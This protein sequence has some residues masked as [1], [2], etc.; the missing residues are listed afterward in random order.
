LWPARYVALLVVTIQL[1]GTGLSG[2]CFLDS[3]LGGI[4]AI[5]VTSLLPRNPVEAVHVA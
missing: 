1:P 4:V 3:L 5:A 2:V